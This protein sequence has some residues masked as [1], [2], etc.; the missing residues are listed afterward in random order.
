MLEDEGND[1]MRIRRRRKMQKENI[2]WRSKIR[3]C[4]GAGQ[5][6]LTLE[7]SENKG[8]TLLAVNYDRYW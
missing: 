3:T 6:T 8:K 5:R 7:K 4:I 2:R 1:Y